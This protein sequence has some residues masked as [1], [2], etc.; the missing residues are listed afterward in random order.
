MYII[1]I[2]KF[3][4]LIGEEIKLDTQPKTLQEEVDEK[5]EIEEENIIEDETINE[6]EIKPTPSPNKVL[7]DENIVFVFKSNSSDKFPGTL[8]GKGWAEKLPLKKKLILWN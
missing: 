6:I 1:I 3:A 5:K 2:P 8:K 7:F 4:K